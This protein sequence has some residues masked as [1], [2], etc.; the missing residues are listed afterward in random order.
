[1]AISFRER[2]GED[3]L[4][5]FIDAMALC[6]LRYDVRRP[7]IDADLVQ[8]RRRFSVNSRRLRIDLGRLPTRPSRA[9]IIRY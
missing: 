6:R 5:Q 2:L 1:L 4:D 7:D 3:R 9:D 8:Q